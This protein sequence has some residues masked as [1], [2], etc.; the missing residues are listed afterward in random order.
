MINKSIQIKNIYYM[1]S[2]AFRVLKDSDY[3][4]I[5]SEEF[6]NVYNLLAELLYRGTVIQIKKGLNKD[7]IACNENIKTIKG[8][9]NVFNTIKEMSKK[10]NNI[11]CDFDEFSENT[12]LNQIIKA[13]IIYLIN[14]DSIDKEIRSKLNSLRTFFDNVDLIN[15]NDVMWKN[16]IFNRNNQ[17][18]RMIINLCYFI[19]NNLLL[20]EEEGKFVLKTFTDEQLNLVFQN[21]VLNYYREYLNAHGIDGSVNA[22]KINYSI[23]YSKEYSGIEFLPEMQTDITIS[24]NTN[25]LIIDT[26]FYS[27]IFQTNREKEKYRNTNMNQIYS[28]VNHYK[29]SN[30]EKRVSGMLLYAMTNES[31]EP[32]VGND[33]GLWFYIDTLDLNNDFIG[34]KNQLDTLIEK[35]LFLS[36]S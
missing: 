2:Y 22:S 14:I 7:Y 5:S 20:T 34:I 28:Y 23:D 12:I 3:E 6:D 33:T 15:L 31:V 29:Y 16:I 24:V 25:I 30:P 17:N 27:K 19:Q 1:L 35:A 4:Y 26:K 36:R 9:I 18:Y 21:F 8:R 10:S 32:F 11:N 13:T